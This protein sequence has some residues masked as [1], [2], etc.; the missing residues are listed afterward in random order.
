MKYKNRFLLIISSIAASSLVI[1]C[2]GSPSE[3]DLK[4]AFLKTTTAMASNGNQPPE[5]LSFNKVGC[6]DDGE[7]AVKCDIEMSLKWP[8]Q[9]P[10]GKRVQ[11][12]RFV[13]GSDGWVKR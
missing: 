6:K 5:I 8:G 13:K 10:T 12:F 1:G 9:E 11:S 3:S 4:N 7:N 2:G